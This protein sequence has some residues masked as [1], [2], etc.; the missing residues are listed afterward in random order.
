MA[1]S[2]GRKQRLIATICIS[3]A[4][5]IAEVSGKSHAFRIVA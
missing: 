5:F 1:F 2:I 4:F 3:L